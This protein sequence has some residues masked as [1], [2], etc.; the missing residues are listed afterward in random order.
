MAAIRADLARE[1][2]QAPGTSAQSSSSAPR[3]AVNDDEDMIVDDDGE[4]RRKRLKIDHSAAQAAPSLTGAVEAHVG[5]GNPSCLG[6]DVNMEA[7]SPSRLG[8]V[9]ARG[10]C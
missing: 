8:A 6:G 7:A 9:S 3:M 2:A 1:A 5:A 10:G 4:D